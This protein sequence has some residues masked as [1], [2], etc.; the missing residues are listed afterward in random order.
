MDLFFLFKFIE[1][2]RLFNNEIK[3]LLLIN[4]IRLFSS[5]DNEGIN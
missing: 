1:I 5:K 3:E 4:Y 2:I